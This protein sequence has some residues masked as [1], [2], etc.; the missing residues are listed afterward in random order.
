MSRLHFEGSGNVRA[1]E[2]VLSRLFTRIAAAVETH[3]F[4]RAKN[5][6]V[7]DDYPIPSPPHRNLQE[8]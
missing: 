3:E 2:R 6:S 7:G 1:K 8:G 5:M 4:G